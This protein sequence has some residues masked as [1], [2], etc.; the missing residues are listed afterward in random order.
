MAIDIRL[1]APSEGGN[2]DLRLLANSVVIDYDRSP[3]LAP[4]PGS[5]VSTPSVILL[6][7]GQ[8]RVNI[9]VEGFVNE[10]GTDQTEGANVIADKIDLET[11]TIQWWDNEITF[12]VS[13][14]SYTV[15]I[16]ACRFSLRPGTE[17]I[18]WDFQLRLI[19]H[20]NSLSTS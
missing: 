15:K 10:T 17:T 13:E 9:T 7:L 2:N 6:D 3:I 12:T 18:K 14:D 4:L 16:A 11:A 19:G 5:T 8:L 1:N 20:H